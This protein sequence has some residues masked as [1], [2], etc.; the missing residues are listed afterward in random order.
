[1]L[2]DARLAMFSALI[3]QHAKRVVDNQTAYHVQRLASALVVLKGT[4]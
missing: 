1:M 2:V 3:S 4:L